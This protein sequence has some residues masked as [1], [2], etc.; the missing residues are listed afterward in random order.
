[1][2]LPLLFLFLSASLVYFL[3]LSSLPTPKGQYDVGV[4]EKSVVDNTRVERFSNSEPRRLFLQVYYPVD[5]GEGFEFPIKPAW[6]GLADSNLG[7][8]S[9]FVRYLNGIKSNAYLGAPIS[10]NEIFPVL[11][12]NTGFMMF[13]DIN[14]VL[15]EHLVSNGYVVVSIGHPYENILPSVDNEFPR[16]ARAVPSDVTGNS[17]E[18][19]DFFYFANG[20][21]ISEPSI[22]SEIRRREYETVNTLVD[23]FEI[24]DDAESRLEF[25]S[26]VINQGSL[27]YVNES[28]SRE[29]LLDFLLTRLHMNF[30]TEVWVRDTQFVANYLGTISAPIENFSKQIKLDGFGVFGM[31]FGGSVAGEFCKVDSRCIAGSNLDGQQWGRNWQIAPDAP[32]LR[33]RHEG[34]PGANDWSYGYSNYDF[35]DYEVKGTFH[36]DFTDIPMMLPNL[37]KIG[38][39]GDIDPAR[40]INI[41]NSV[42]LNFFD[43]YLKEYE[44]DL[45]GP[46]QFEEITTA[47]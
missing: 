39:I 47:I 24:I 34:P 37:D 1:M 36:G 22:E 31:S 41:L 35:Y 10:Q 21:D 20:G 14:T 26:T 11:L 19:P 12:Y 38:L 6:S 28:L 43:K 45:V 40:I 9:S 13:P 33:W 32:F 15:V 46:F 17:L 8:A 2:L 5:K 23:Q 7:G 18:S 42:Q 44:G 16:N 4:F 3:P 29:E 30:S 27:N 25:V